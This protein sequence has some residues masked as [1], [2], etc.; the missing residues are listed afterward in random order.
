MAKYDINFTPNPEKGISYTVITDDS[1]DWN[2]VPSN[3]YFYDKDTNLPYYKNSNDDILSVFSTGGSGNT[4]Y[5]ADDTIGSARELTLTDNVTFKGIDTNLGTRN[6]IL[7]DSNGNYILENF[8]NGY[9]RRLVTSGD[10]YAV[11][12]KSDQTKGLWIALGSE[13]AGSLTITNVKGDSNSLSLNTD[14]FKAPDIKWVSNGA[15]HHRIRSNGTTST[16]LTQASFF[17]QGF[18]GFGFNVGSSTPIGTEDISLQ[19]D[20]LISEKLELSSKEHGILLN[21]VNNTEMNAILSP[22]LNEIVFNTDVNLLYRWTGTDWGLIAPFG[23]LSITDTTGSPTYYGNYTDAI[24][25]A[26]DGDTIVQYGDIEETSGN[27]ITIDKNITINMQGHTYKN[28]SADS[29]NC[30]FVS[31]DKVVKFVDGNIERING[32]YDQYGNYAIRG[33]VNTD[34]TFVGTTIKNDGGRVIGTGDDGVIDG[35]RFITTNLPAVSNAAVSLSGLIKNAIFESEGTNLF[36]NGC[37]IYNSEVTSTYVNT[38]QNN[39]V[40]RFCKFKQ[41]STSGDRGL[42][43]SLSKAYYCE[44]FNAS[45]NANSIEVSGTDS[46]LW[47]CIGEG[48]ATNK[49]GIE[50]TDSSG[51]PKGLYYC[52]G[53]NTGTGY[54]GIIGNC[55]EVKNC[56]FIGGPSSTGGVFCN[57]NDATIEN[58]SI[59]CENTAPNMRSFIDSSGIGTIRVYNC[60]IESAGTDSTNSMFFGNGK[61]VYLTD[62]KIKGGTG[63][64]NVNGNSQTT[65][66][67]AFGN[68]ILD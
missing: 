65:S 52:T 13:L 15:E 21:R 54:G 34:L 60:L 64:D 40:A 22:A 57:S 46:E 58:C 48:S 66:S 61:T 11:I 42:I 30:F 12:A 3:T 36:N 59:K 14:N 27:D 56:T 31:S 25:G 10:N 2:D 1:N 51:T 20:T 55:V 37:E 19:G 6:L 26:S 23:L 43:I 45:T 28:S 8:N 63:I 50:I 35:G 67:D 39:S 7:K 62:N 9:H 41:T 18:S 33:A 47:Y 16:S 32:T 17:I 49:A 29:S 5:S 4:I 68:I 44:V 53:I 38:V 24:A